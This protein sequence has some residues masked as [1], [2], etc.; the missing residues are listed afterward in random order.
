M[1][2]L[3]P[4]FCPGKNRYCTRAYSYFDPFRV[5]GDGEC[6]EHEEIV[7]EFTGL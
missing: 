5:K 3:Y 1:A 6:S 2:I 4:R 7:K